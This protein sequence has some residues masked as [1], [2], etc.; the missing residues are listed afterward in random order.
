MNILPSWS[1]KEILFILLWRV[2]I[3][4]SL[5]LN[6]TETTPNPHNVTRN[7]EKPTQLPDGKRDKLGK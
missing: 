7:V 1:C 5:P 6:G 3:V 4:L 2:L